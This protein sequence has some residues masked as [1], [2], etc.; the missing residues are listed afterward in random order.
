MVVEYTDAI[1]T[2]GD[3]VLQ[4]YYDV[5]EFFDPREIAPNLKDIYYIYCSNILDN[6]Y[7]VSEDVFGLGSDV[8]EE[9]LNDLGISREDLPTI[10]DVCAMLNDLRLGY[11]FGGV[12]YNTMP[13]T[14][15]SEV[16]IEDDSLS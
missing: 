11:T 1:E 6:I 3:D 16:E 14:L 4:A 7:D 13:Q 15:L 8:R 2:F 9:W 5:L 12:L 10:L